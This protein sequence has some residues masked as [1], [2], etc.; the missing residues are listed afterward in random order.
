MLQT[1]LIF[2]TGNVLAF[3]NEAHTLAQARTRVCVCARALALFLSDHKSWVATICTRILRRRH[4]CCGA[5]ARPLLC[6]SCCFKSSWLTGVQ[7]G[8]IHAFLLCCNLSTTPASRPLLSPSAPDAPP[9]P[10]PPPAL[11][12][13]LGEL[14]LLPS[15]VSLFSSCCH[16]SRWCCRVSRREGCY[17]RE[18]RPGGEG[19][20]GEGREWL[21]GKEER[22]GS[23][24][25]PLGRVSV[26]Q[27][28]LGRA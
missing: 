21:E 7:E 9:A 14:A 25:M 2:N 4:W 24:G 17:E 23:E 6:S 12:T 20:E 10:H 27:T 5:K 8:G 3:D 22:E 13:P 26:I 19:K 15:A 28:L 1:L 16:W 18:G 11:P